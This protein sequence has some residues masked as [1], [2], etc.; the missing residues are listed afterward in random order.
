M[1]L[2]F[3]VESPR[4]RETVPSEA[5]SGSSSEVG[6]EVRER[7]PVR[8][9]KS[10]SEERGGLLGRRTDSRES[11]REAG[12]RF[13]RTRP[14]SPVL[15]RNLHPVLEELGHELDTRQPA[16]AGG[17]I[18]DLDEAMK[19]VPNHDEVGIAVGQAEDGDGGQVPRAREQHVVSRHE[20]LLGRQAKVGRKLLESLDSRAI[21]VRLAGFTEPPV[22]HGNAVALEKGLQGCRT[23]VHCRGLHDLRDEPLSASCHGSFGREAVYQ[24]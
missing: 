2:F 24:F 14:G 13:L 21:D 17:G 16:T 15:G 4:E 3:L 18:H 10:L 9:R 19:Y 11:A 5:R 6:V 8:I 12:R 1:L 20:N 23:A 7:A 22:A